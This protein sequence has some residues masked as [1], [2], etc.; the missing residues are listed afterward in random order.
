M[1][2]GKPDPNEVVA[3]ILGFGYNLTADRQNSIQ[4]FDA[5]SAT[6]IVTGFHKKLFSLKAQVKWDPDQFPS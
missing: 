2:V 5:N 3:E 4:E 1:G 6:T